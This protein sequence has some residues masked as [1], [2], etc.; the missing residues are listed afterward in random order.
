MNSNKTVKR[1]LVLSGG[2]AKGAFAFGVIQKIIEKNIKIDAIAGT[3][4]GALNAALLS[5]G[6]METGATIWR[7][8]EQN[9]VYPY[10]WPMCSKVTGDFRDIM[11]H[12]HIA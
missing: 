8:L 3:S 1:G 12:R 5:T 11:R 9:R 4:V 7:T 10:R 2:G 6:E